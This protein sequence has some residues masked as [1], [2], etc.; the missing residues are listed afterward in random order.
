M[1]VC[2]RRLCDGHCTSSFSICSTGVCSRSNDSP[3]PA[4]LIVSCLGAAARGNIVTFGTCASTYQVTTR[5]HSPASVGAIASP[6]SA[7]SSVDLPAFTFP[8]MATRSGS[9]KRARLCCSQPAAAPL[10]R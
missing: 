10:S 6:T 3:P 5:V 7:L 2:A 4:R 1:R 8:A 9:S